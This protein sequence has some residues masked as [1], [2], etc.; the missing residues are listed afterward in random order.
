MRKMLCLTL[1]ALC[2]VH[3]PVL[4]EDRESAAPAP[5]ESEIITE[6]DGTRT[7]IHRTVI[8]APPAKVWTA[9]STEEGWKYWGVAFARMDVRN[10]GSI[11]SGYVPDATAGDPRNI[12]HRILAMVPERLMA[13][14]VSKA[15]PEPIDPELFKSMWAVYEL[16]PLPGERTQLTISG[17]GYGEGE[18]YDRMLSFFERGNAYS[19]KLMRTNLAAAE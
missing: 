12:T 6:P 15:P 11:E 14:Q 5:V 2:L 18:Q 8:D 10:G 3:A 1:A 16:E 7:L 13:I 19:I 4:A 9:F 17:Y